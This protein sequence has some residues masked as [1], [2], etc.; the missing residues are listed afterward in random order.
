MGG[1]SSDGL[2]VALGSDESYE[3]RAFFTFLGD[4]IIAVTNKKRLITLQRSEWRGLTAAGAASK[5]ASEGW[6]ITG[7]ERVGES[8]QWRVTEELKTEG[9]WE[10]DD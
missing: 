6:S 10:A 8:G 5:T 2:K 1:W 4:Q 3:Y 9:E 7:R